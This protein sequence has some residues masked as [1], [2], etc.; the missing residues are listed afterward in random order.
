[1]KSII[2]SKSLEIFSADD[3]CYL[4]Y[5]NDYNHLMQ[6]FLEGTKYA[7][8]LVC[9]TLLYNARYKELFYQYFMEGEVGPIQIRQCLD[10]KLPVKE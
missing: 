5:Y 9:S 8:K 7:L 2:L 6:I 1:M 10:N 4:K 3:K